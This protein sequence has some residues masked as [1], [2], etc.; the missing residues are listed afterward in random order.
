[1]IY[2]D[3][4]FILLAF[5]LEDA[6]GSS[7]EAQATAA[8]STLT[9]SPLRFNPDA[10][11]RAR[12]AP[13]EIDLWRGRL[14]IGE[15]HDENCWALGGAAGHAGFFGAAKGGGDF[16]RAMMASLKGVDASVATSA[17]VKTFIARANVPGSRALGWDT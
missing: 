10:S 7:F 8:L 9:S 14:L 6:G 17:T 11:A 16:A 4:G 5:A 12:S 3:L 13:T 15:V 1:S 2:S